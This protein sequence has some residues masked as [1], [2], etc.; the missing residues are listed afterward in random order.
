[1]KDLR[2]NRRTYYRHA[3]KPHHILSIAL[4]VA[5][6]LTTAAEI[7]TAPTRIEQTRNNNFPWST[8]FALQ[9]ACNEGDIAQARKLV[10]KGA[11]INIALHCACASQGQCNELIKELL[12][13]GADVNSTAVE[14]C[15][16]LYVAI[17]KKKYGECGGEGRG[18]RATWVDAY[19]R[20]A[21]VVRILLEAGADPNACSGYDRIP[22]II[23]AARS[24]D[25]ATVELLLNRGADVNGREKSGNGALHWAVAGHHNH[26]VALLLQHGAEP[27]IP[28]VE[29]DYVDRAGVTDN[30]VGTTPMH[31]A[32]KFNNPEA[33]ALLIQHGADI[34]AQDEAKATPF[35]Y[36]AESASVGVLKLIHQHGADIKAP[37]AIDRLKLRAA[38]ALEYLRYLAETGYP[39]EQTNIFTAACTYNKPE[40]LQLLKEIGQKVP[41]ANSKG[42]SALFNLLLHANKN[43]TQEDIINMISL[44]VDCGA[45]ISNMGYLPLCYCVDYGYDRVFFRLIELGAPLTSPHPAQKRLLTA[46]A[47]YP[48]SVEGRQCIMAWLNENHADIVAE[49]KAEF[50]RREAAEAKNRINKQLIKEA[51]RGNL[52]GVKAALA[53]G[54]DINYVDEFNNTALSST[55]GMHVNLPVT[56]YLLQNGADPNFCPTVNGKSTPHPLT[57]CKNTELMKLLAQHG[58][59]FNKPGNSGDL[60]LHTIA[61][62]NSS[63]VAC[64][65]ELGAAPTLTDAEGRSAL[66]MARTT[67]SA[68]MLLQAAPQMLP[69][70]DHAGNTAL[71][72]IAMVGPGNFDI[73]PTDLSGLPTGNT[74]PKINTN[75]TGAI[76]D[77]ELAH[78]YLTAGLSPNTPNK[79]GQT[80][81]MQAAY[82][83]NLRLVT[84]LLKMGADATARDH[85]GRSA[86]GYALISGHP[87]IIIRLKQLNAPGGREE[88]LLQAVAAGNTAEVE[89]FIRDG[90]SVKGI[91]SI[92]P[93]AALIAALHGREKMLKLLLDNGVIIAQSNK[94][95]RRLL[96]LAVAHNNAEA[97]NLLI[98]YGAKVHMQG[99]L[100]QR[101]HPSCRY[102][103]A[104]HE[105]AAHG[106]ADMVKLLY[107]YG[108]SL[109]TYRSP[110]IYAIYSD[111]P[112]TVRTLVELGADIHG[113]S[114]DSVS[115]YP[116][117]VAVDAEKTDMVSLLLELG[118]NPDGRTKHPSS[119][120]LFYA[121][122]RHNAELVRMLLEAGAQA[123]ATDNYNQSHLHSA[124]C[125]QTPGVVALFIKYGADVNRQ[126]KVSGR[127]TTPLI[128]TI[129]YRNEECTEI[130][131]LL[132]EAGANPAVKD[133]AGKT[134]LDYAEEKG[135]TATIQL[136]KQAKP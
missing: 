131:R 8:F 103:T 72:H 69:L 6:P 42:E 123:D 130:V 74:Q 91:D 132:L 82:N 60:F 54:A 34:H 29:R 71:H 113:L 80:P 21:E 55:Y 15:T 14:H 89:Q 92:G 120:P 81:L 40:V 62:V 85:S 114:K 83:G 38:S 125:T 12:A 115:L 50:E 25:I 109:K 4:W 56:E 112:Q 23:E 67:D 75:I 124:V 58:A 59:D 24:G 104:L 2:K 107:N 95:E 22:P 30:M 45:D 111:N 110:L 49:E 43:V 48:R 36:T 116:L 100:H 122:N 32:A 134:A 5:A 126:S 51:Q 98:K 97:V 128:N 7:P 88:Q 99:R 121:M 46:R 101:L 37:Q 16:P 86:L 117:C 136:L 44:L 53:Q 11:D 77:M 84:L 57:R 78:L 31:C 17:G 35:V 127:C 108:S 3:M 129:R 52:D 19:E 96:N 133:A 90:L 18:S 28:S 68:L 70:T 27:D 73:C 20:Q 10:A 119:S 102:G 26:I 76:D 87:D 79:Q 1:M 135:Y 94:C 39:F 106:H 47:S 61:G 13:A 64:A 105:A 63:L 41:S 9:E 93:T 66:M 65:L 33:A 118:A